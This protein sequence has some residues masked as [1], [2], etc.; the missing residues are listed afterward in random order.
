MRTQKPAE[1]VQIEKILF[2]IF[3][4]NDREE[5]ITNNLFIL[6]VIPPGLVR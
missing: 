1:K 5:N 3:I 6:T 2:E 4:A